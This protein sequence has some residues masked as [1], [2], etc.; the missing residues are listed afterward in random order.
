MQY[1]ELVR[2]GLHEQVQAGKETPYRGSTN[3]NPKAGGPKGDTRGSLS[4]PIP[5]K[6]QNFSATFYLRSKLE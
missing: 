3:A 1:D 4:R 2:R 5:I 6:F